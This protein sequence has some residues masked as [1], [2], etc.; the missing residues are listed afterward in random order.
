MNP[1][2]GTWQF[3]VELAPYKIPWQE[4]CGKP[5]CKN[6]LFVKLVIDQGYESKG[7][8]VSGPPKYS[9][10]ISWPASTPADFDIQIY[11][12]AQL[13]QFLLSRVSTNTTVLISSTKTCIMYARIRARDAGV[14]APKYRTWHL[15]SPLVPSPWQH[16]TVTFHLILDPLLFGFIPQSAMPVIWIILALVV[17]GAYVSKYLITYLES[18]AMRVDEKSIMLGWEEKKAN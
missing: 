14:K 12:P 17:V 10:R 1:T 9:L 18:V 11:T 6:E 7:L 5:N 8:L 3:G 4:V 13:S 15:F 2:P 16:S